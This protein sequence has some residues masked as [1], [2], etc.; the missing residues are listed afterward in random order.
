MNRMKER[1][2]GLDCHILENKESRYSKAYLT[3]YFKD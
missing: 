2:S 1:S 3:V